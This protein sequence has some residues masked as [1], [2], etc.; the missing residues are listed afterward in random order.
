[1]KNIEP[2][3][4]ENL[5]FPERALDSNAPLP[6]KGPEE[7]ILVMLDIQQTLISLGISYKHFPFLTLGEE[8]QFYRDALQRAGLP[9]NMIP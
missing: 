9:K 8:I 7:P 4:Y 3:D 1:M 2:E 6:L 5:Q